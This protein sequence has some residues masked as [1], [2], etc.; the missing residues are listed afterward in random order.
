MLYVFSGNCIHVC[1]G[2]EYELHQGDFCLL[3]Y[4]VAHKIINNTDQCVL[5][6]FVIKR[7]M[8]DKMCPSLLQEESALANFFK[9][10]LYGTSYYPTIVFP[11]GDDRAVLYYLMAMYSEAL[12]DMSHCELILGG[13][14]N[15]L[16]GILLRGFTP[17][18]AQPS[19]QKNAAISA[20]VDYIYENYQNATLHSVAEHF[21]YSDSYMSKLISSACGVSFK[22]LLRQAK[23]Q[24]ATWLLC[25]SNLTVSQIAAE[26]NYIDALH[27]ARN[28]RKEYKMSPGEYHAMFQSK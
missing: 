22:D 3:E 14:M 7:E 18:I 10:A 24:R 27:F 19:S 25:Y 16:F 17:Q 28:F 20:V 23:M 15:V 5:I 6:E 1:N 12:S 26:T 9:N 11:T 13:F 2:R 8:F 4:G 21:K